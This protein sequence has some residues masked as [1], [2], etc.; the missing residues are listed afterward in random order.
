M[1]KATQTPD[2][3]AYSSTVRKVLIVKTDGEAIDQFD[4]KIDNLDIDEINITDFNTNSEMLTETIDNTNN[5]VTFSQ[6]VTKIIIH[7][8][9]DED[10]VYVNFNG[11]NATTDDYE[12]EAGSKEFLP[13][14]IEE[15]T[16][17]NIISDNSEGTVV[18]IMGLWTP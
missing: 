15:G 7:N 14:K 9:S 17:L 13:L 2:E 11:E 4:V 16:G 6:D 3:N 5:E 1:V 12:I 10:T 8:T 18:K